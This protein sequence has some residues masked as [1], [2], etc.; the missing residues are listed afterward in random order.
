[1]IYVTSDLHLN[2]NK[3]F[4]Y[5]PRNCY[6]VEEM[7]EKIFERFSYFQ[8]EDELYILG[9]LS[10]SNDDTPVKEFLVQL[11]NQGVKVYIIRGNHDTDRRIEL[12]KEYSNVEVYDAKYLKYK[13]YHF[14][15]THFPCNTSNLE[16]EN[17][18]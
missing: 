14:Y 12:Y 10:L 3:E 18:K 1:M 9:D 5:T 8:K 15:L 16:K 4:V 17:L 2:H 7:N 6:S 11:Q 13:G